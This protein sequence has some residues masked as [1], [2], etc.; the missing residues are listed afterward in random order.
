MAE[1]TTT[2]S[3]KRPSGATDSFNNAAKWNDGTIKDYSS[4]VVAYIASGAINQGECVIAETAAVDT[5]PRVKVTPA[6]GGATSKPLGVALNTAAAGE[7]VR[8]ARDIGWCRCSVTTS[9]AD[10]VAMTG[11]AA[12]A[13]H[14]IYRAAGNVLAAT[15]IGLARSGAVANVFGSTAGVLVQFV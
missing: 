10:G 14:V 9:V 8:V 11:S 7:I 13:G 15:D 5:G 1:I 3:A 12:T 4:Q 2:Q 6:S